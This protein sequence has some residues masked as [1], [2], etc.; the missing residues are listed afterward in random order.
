MVA[1]AE[2]LREKAH[3][4]ALTHQP[5]ARYSTSRKLWRSVE[6][7]V[8]AI[9]SFVGDIGETRGACA[10]PAEEWLLDHAEFIQ[11]QAYLIED[12][13]AEGSLSG[14][15]EL[16]KIRRPRILELCAEFLELTEGELD[17]K[18]FTTFVNAYQDI[19]VLSVAEVWAIPAALRIALI[20]RLAA[21]T[22]II[23]ERR[24]ICMQTDRLLRR[25][26]PERMNPERLNAALEDA[27]HD[28]PLSGPLIA[29]LIQHLREW[30]DDTS[31]VR[32]WL[33][34][35]LENGADDL[36]RIVSYD[37]EWQ[38]SLQAE[39]GR[40]IGSL[41]LLSRW[42]WRE[43][44]PEICLV[45]QTLRKDRTGDYPLLDYASQDLLRRRVE[46]LAKRMRVP[47]NLVAEQAVK[48]AAERMEAAA[49]SPEPE[50]GEP[51]PL[52][53]REANLAYYLLE[54]EGVMRLMQALKQCAKPRKMPE[55]ALWRRSTAS[56]FT[57]VGLAFAVFAAAFALWLAGGRPAMAAGPFARVTAAAAAVLIAFPALEW[58]VAL[59]HWLI[60][61]CRRTMPLLKYD[62]SAGI[63]ED[64]ATM[65]VVPV[66]WSE[67]EEARV[68]AERLEL[69]YLATRDPN[70]HFALL[71]DFRDAPEERMPG[72]DAVL[73]SAKAEIARL[74]AAYPGS[75]FHL[76]HRRRMYN[77]S[78]GKWIG[79]ERKRGKLVEFVEMLRGRTDTSY[80]TAVGDAAF[81]KRV[82]YL[83]TLD[84]DTELPLSAAQRMVGAMHLPYNRP[85]LNR[86]RT[87][88]VQGYGVLQPRIG[89]RH[90][91]A[92][93]SRLAYLWSRDTG[94]DPY[95]FA[96]SD[97]YQDSVGQGIFVG[98][99]I[100]DVAA[101][102]ET[103][104]GRI[105]D[106]AV[107]SHDLLEGGFLRAGLLSDVELI[108]GN[109]AT[110]L[111][112]Q[113]R[114]HRWARGDW[115]LVLWLMPK[116]RDRSGVRRPVD[117]PAI[118]R[119]QIIDNVRRNLAAP[120]LTAAL[121]AGFSG[122]FGSPMRW[123]ALVL[124]TLLVPALRYAVSMRKWE[125]LPAVLGQCL[126]SFLTLPYQ[127]A[128]MADAMV[129]AL[130]R[131]LISKRLLL[132]WVSMADVE[133]GEGERR[134]PALL[135]IPAGYMLIA[136]F[137]ALFLLSG[138]AAAVRA[139][140]AV[141]LIW[142]AAPAAIRYLDRPPNIASEHGLSGE[143]SGKLREL[144]RQI[145]AFF[146][147][148]VTEEENWL[149]P[150]N[151]Q[152]DPP[153]GVAS[154]TSPTNIGLYLAC[155]LAARDFGFIGTRELVRRIGR[156][157]A[158]IE[159][160]EKW[161]GHLY[162][163]YNTRT[164]QPLPP[165]YVSTVD[166]GNM[167]VCLMA[168]RQG[169]AEW[170][171]R[172]A[173]DNGRDEATREATSNPAG[174][175][176]ARRD[177][178][179]AAGKRE[180]EDTGGLLEEGRALLD[181]L[182]NI[183]GG[184]DFRPL[185]DHR[186]RLFALGYNPDACRRDQILYDLAASEA[187]QASFAAIALGQVSVAH[188]HALGR[189]MARMNGK[190]MLLSWSGTMFEYLM[191]WL[192]LRTYRGTIWDS[193]YRA[194]VERQAGYAR[195]RGV[196]MGVSES[197]FYAF[198]YEMNYQYR[199]FGVP[200]LGLRKGL[201]RDLVV[202]PYAALLALPYSGKEALR[203]LYEMERLGARGKYG[204]Y[205]AIDFT[206]ERMPKNRDFMVV[207]SFMAHHQGMSMIA[208]AN[209]LLP[210]P[211]YERFHRNKE[212]RAAELL[213]QERIPAKPKYVGSR[214]LM[215]LCR[216]PEKFDEHGGV[217]EFKEARTQRPE[218]CLLGGGRFAVMITAAGGGYCQYGDIAVTR[219]AEDP[220]TDG[221]GNFM[222]IRDVTRDRVWSPTFLPAKTVPGRQHIRF[223]QD[224]AHFSR[225]D[226]DIRTELTVCAVPDQ[227][228]EL[229][230]LMV[231][232]AGREPAVIEVTTF[233]ELSLVRPS[234]EE[235]HP[236]FSKLF[237]RTEYVSALDCLAAGRRPREAG[238]K[239]IWAAHGLYAES[240][241]IGPAEYETDRAAFI[242]RGHS[243]AEPQSLRAGL[244]GTVG[245]VADPVFAMRRRVEIAP[246]DAVRF[247]AVTA[248]SE[249]KEEALAAVERCRDVRFAE[250]IFEMCWHR[251]RVEMR[252]LQMTPA[253]AVLFQRLA[254]HIL[255]PPP[256]RKERKERIAR[257]RKGQSA[258]WAHGISGEHPIVAVR[259]AEKGQ[260]PFVRKMLAA[261]EYLRLRQ[262]TF[263]LILLNEAEGS[264]RHD[265]KS[266]LIREAEHG[267][268]RFGAP[269]ANV[270]VLNAA[271]LDGDDLNLILAAAQIEL[272]A[273]GASLGAQLRLPEE[274]ESL[275]EALVPVA[276]RNR[277]GA[278]AAA[279][280]RDELQS[281]NG[282]G[283]FAAGGAEYRIHVSNG[284]YLPAPWINVMAN[285]EFGCIVSEL[286]TGYTWWKN[287]REC[288]LTPWSNDPVADPPGEICYIRDE[289]SGE[290]WRPAVPGEGDGAAVEASH[291]W[292]YSRFAGGRLGIAWEMSVSVPLRD[293][294]KIVRLSLR[295]DSGEKRKLSV[296]YYAEWV[297]GVRR[298]G[299]MPFIR[300][301]WA[302]GAKALIA[303]NLY[304][305]TFRD[306]RAFLAVYPAADT[307]EYS[308]TADRGEF[309]GRFGSPAL[310]A[311]LSRRRLSGKS[312][313]VSDPCGAVQAGFELEPGGKCDVY[314]LLGCAPSR[315]AA[316]SLL[317]KYADPK[318]C[319]AAAREVRDYWKDLLGRIRVKTPS[320]ETDWLLNGWLLYQALC[321]RMWARTAFYQSGGAYGYR[322]QLQDSLALLNAAPEMTRR[323]ILLHAARQYAEGDVQHWWHEEPGSGI[324]TGFSDDLLWLPYVAARYVDHTADRSILDEKAPFLSSPPLG[325]GERERYEPGAE[326]DGEG[327]VYEHCCRAID[328]ALSRMGDLGLPLIGAGDWNDG[329]NMVGAEGRGI[330]VWLGWF[331]C[332]V[333]RRFEPISR[334]RGDEERAA[335]YETER[336]RLASA[337]HE[338]A[339]DGAWYR[340]AMSDDGRWLGSILNEEC[341]IDA[342]AQSWS[343]ISGAGDPERMR[344]AMES[345]DRELVDRETSVV[346]LLTP[347]F[348]QTVP[349][350][351]YIQGYPPGIR[352]NG[353]QYTHG[354]IWSIVAWSMLGEGNKAFEL[355]NMLNPVNHTRTESEVRRY[356]GE[357]YVMAADVYSKEPRV[358]RAGWTWYTGAA[359]W[360]YQ[361]GLEWILGIRREGDRLRIAPCIPSEWREYE[362]HYRFGA[363]VYRIRVLN[364]DGKMAGVRK[365]TIGG[366]EAAPG[367]GRNREE[368][369]VAERDDPDGRSADGRT[370]RNGP[371]VAEVKDGAALVSL[372]DEG[373]EFAVEVTM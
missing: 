359:G 206:A 102:A 155:V 93:R 197:G 1:N 285:P 128:V 106:N 299:R 70:I 287:S 69:H 122:H 223:A 340:R 87:R 139:G 169:L 52:L 101:F 5:H 346:R 32:E 357:P 243:H 307:A 249:E 124:A 259:V 328:L 10:E 321:C 7:D 248:V 138:D 337:L 213:L 339:W 8:Q 250:R 56:Y 246:G 162:N 320:R 166:S 322:D 188:W 107:L 347:P 41:R 92:L 59:T 268:N 186:A 57:M 341:R 86:K 130:Y 71:G 97:P 244:R 369:W 276:A 210:S 172:D 83:I 64:A 68:M 152:I 111:S 85:R 72:D 2:R 198:D 309:L 258:L 229:R 211:M 319:E 344:K 159:R 260:L 351:G 81:L 325:E 288:K 140:I 179:M 94:V 212:V 150:D 176:A 296:T 291:G 77:P 226:G 281:F 49:D 192:F 182:D 330:S 358:G 335:R 362:V 204:F 235:A 181:R 231:A 190:P 262:L 365:V 108:D 11:E 160:M 149:P 54:D 109:P 282:W 327:S 239:E 121:L 135:G 286:G 84:A 230:L 4:L 367:D 98:K 174:E 280:D 39:T 194:A 178:E 123:L 105:P 50:Q 142:A 345:F 195:E 22:E 148:Y 37:F 356:A 51:R 151:V 313:I 284:H 119:W 23:R 58:A 26:E 65:V 274:R 354:A 19:A 308:W 297:I 16:V 103:V 214:A 269:A 242:G 267:V 143:E 312:G 168:V 266:A 236:A 217:R 368:I 225:T 3:E 44:F 36:D 361:A 134:G 163:W 271:E 360:M 326:R 55:N 238:E 352:E 112:H 348:E 25:I 67:P 221:G 13:L 208:L 35:K 132:E 147:D 29:H 237:V 42:D 6:S 114:Q 144:A 90:E 14:L 334:M 251:S 129:R 61:C 220:L 364:P 196:P 300:S 265:L 153:K 370:S 45:E 173:A 202:A 133:R 257:N 279:G 127:S 146:E 372:T 254:G 324:R 263:D 373:R 91:T 336:R 15:P 126:L 28:I 75:P 342:I 305:E 110:F 99:G 100:I 117:L 350:P 21:V 96:V 27:G 40:L 180:A 158:T 136:L 278:P 371:P 303:E 311:A 156:T 60:E 33:S 161:E 24:G 289:E 349:S 363:S 175:A 62:F 43:Q 294:V 277:F 47:E 273:G 78:E 201:E 224:R 255:Y 89:I 177:G 215:R 104:C 34:C 200:G 154:R 164:L 233:Q 141:A 157:V 185:Y 187:R 261:H 209:L 295:N 228:A 310:P 219:R 329:M 332:D 53:P 247:V 199:A 301:E 316:E 76:Y 298:Q 207:R 12:S 252:H 80:T 323:Q 48:L 318:N 125:G 46:K 218:V 234:V 18:A 315:D 256:L 20:R 317:G 290:A 9:Q 82:R 203:A 183:I 216:K 227:N 145:W 293:T 270:H 343:V 88:V 222:Y 66:V 314:I 116:V 355:F 366:G 118:V 167:I 79:W 137:A 191:P 165:R 31:A 275:P 95:A 272:K 240:A 63:P 241:A 245:S 306:A 292:G 170:L 120:M 184:T 171:E 331:L 264:L 38:M 189:S 113:K 338:H 193:T 73:E 17:E 131:M 30:A 333:L 232:N 353:A 115:Q 304:Q 253:D 205:E 74:N 283:G 302:D